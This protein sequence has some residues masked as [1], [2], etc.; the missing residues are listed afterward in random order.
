MRKTLLSVVGLLVVVTMLLAPL[1]GSVKAQTAIPPQPERQY[2]ELPQEVIDAFAGGMTVDEFLAQNKGPIPAALWDYTD[3]KI[4]V[5]IE[6][7]APSLLSNLVAS[8]KTI[9]SAPAATQRNYVAD[10]MKA[11]EPLTEKVADLG[12]NVISQYTKVYNGVLALVPGKEISALRSMPGVKA[13]HRAPIF[14]PTLAS[15]VPLI[16]ADEVWN[17]T[18]GYDGEGVTIAVIDTGIDYTHA[19]LDG[20]GTAAAYAANDPAIIEE[21]SFP[22]AK[23]IGGYDFA[24]TQYDANGT[25]PEQLIPVPDADPLDENGHGTHVASTAAGVGV[26]GV[27]GK[28]VAPAASLYAFKVFGASGSTNLVVDALERAMD[29]NQDGNLSDRVDVIN[30][31]LGSSWG[32]ADS[33][34]PEQVAIDLISKMGTV[35]VVSAGNENDVSYITGSPAVADA[36]ISVAAS[37]TGYVTLP[38]IKYGTSEVPYLP[39]N[40]FTDAITAGL[41]DVD[42]VDG[43]ATGLLCDQN[44]AP[45]DALQ[46]KIAL[47][48]RGTCNFSAKVHNAAALGAVGVIIYN[49]AASLDDFVS[50]NVG[51][52]TLPTGHTLYNFGQTLKAANGSTVTV[53]P[54]SDVSI[55]THGAAD[56][57]ADFSSRG[58]RGYD[59]KLKP[60]IT[61]PGVN[62][63]AAA[64]GTGSEGVSYNG[65]SMAAPHVTGVAALMKQAHP[66]WSVEQIKAAMMSTADDLNYDD[67][68][69]YQ[70]V[71]RTGAGRV[72]AYNAVFT[73]TI[74]TG[75]ADLV[76]LSWGLVEFDEQAEEYDV[77]EVK[78]ITLQN[79][80]SSAHS[81]YILTGFTDPNNG[82]GAQLNVQQ[83]IVVAPNSSG[84]IPVTLTLYP[85]EI[86][87]SFPNLEEYYGFVMIYDR[88]SGDAVRLPFYFVP[89]PYNTL[90]EVPG[91]DTTLR[92]DGTDTAAVDFDVTGSTYSNLWPMTLVGQDANEAE[93][94][95]YADLRAVGMDN[96]GKSPAGNVLTVAFANWGSLH[97]LQPYYNNDELYMD[98]DEDG[99]ADYLF[100]NYNWGAVGTTSGDDDNEWIVLE[101]DIAT[102]TLYLGSP[103]DIEA[104][105]NSGVSI[106]MLPAEYAGFDQTV[107][108]I[109]SFG[110]SIDSIDFA[111]TKDEGPSGTFDYLNAPFISGLTNY[112]P[113]GGE[114][115]TLM[116][117]LNDLDSYNAAKPEGLLLIDF[118]GK[119][120]AGQSYLVPLNVYGFTYLP[121]IHR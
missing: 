63:F 117:A 39:A 24:G 96:G 97:A 70:V 51:D 27:I 54:D 16:Q 71:P 57:V 46:G 49:A 64:M 88:E 109:S 47:I 65:T 21:G 100:F 105:F 108:P 113:L 42:T 116:A 31:S 80:D 13:I 67:P 119:P 40:P 120:G 112:D 45:A 61:A 38:T 53:G 89:R 34:D 60:E 92:K 7:E 41:V 4:A 20:V 69:G 37:S 98:V 52:E 82:Y 50:M 102:D 32:A 11:Q 111:G 91:G 114:L 58:P 103:Y 18:T 19:A 99:T 110:Y 35:V 106:W 121:L 81:Y 79:L 17:A 48:Q 72:N 93:V 56:V 3:K 85:S 66:T 10:L 25:T 104:D 23:V 1:Q 90:T 73:K 84:S 76:S 44:V 87:N 107:D 15:S 43:A 68:N 55:F 95:D 30:M 5:V 78:N 74:A 29:P 59:S 12:G 22:T 28:G 8:G 118:N 94:A 83:S 33:S 75:D 77:P 6:M 86:Y 62:I 9:D 14:E 26:D 2:E 115:T 36:A 101:V